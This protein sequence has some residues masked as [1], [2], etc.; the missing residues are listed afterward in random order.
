L[1]VPPQLWIE[2]LTWIFRFHHPPFVVESGALAGHNGP[3]CPYARDG[4]FKLLS[5]VIQQLFLWG[6][7]IALLTFFFI[8]NL[9]VRIVKVV[10]EKQGYQEVSDRSS[11]LQESLLAESVYYQIDNTGTTDAQSDVD[12][13]ITIKRVGVAKTV[14]IAIYNLFIDGN[15][16]LTSFIHVLIL[17]YQGI[18]EA[19][20]SF[21]SCGRY[22]SNYYAIT[23]TDI[24]CYSD[25]YKKWVP[26]YSLLMTYLL[27]LPIVFIVVIAILRRFRYHPRMVRALGVIYMTYQPLFYWFEGY[28]VFRRLLIIAIVFGSPAV[29][30]KAALFKVATPGVIVGIVLLAF[31]IIQRVSSPFITRTENLLEELSLATLT[32]IAWI[33]N[34]THLSA[35]QPYTR[36][37]FIVILIT[38]LPVGIILFLYYLLC[39]TLIRT[40]IARVHERMAKLYIVQQIGEYTSSYKVNLSLLGS[41]ITWFGSFFTTNSKDISLLSEKKVYSVAATQTS[42][43]SLRLNSSETLYNN[44]LGGYNEPAYDN[45]ADYPHETELID[46]EFIPIS[47]QERRSVNY[48]SPS[49]NRV[50]FDIGDVNRMTGYRL[51]QEEK[52]PELEEQYQGLPRSEINKELKRLWEQLSD[53]AK[54]EYER[55]A[56]NTHDNEDN[57]PFARSLP[58]IKRMTGYMLFAKQLRPEL[59]NSEDLT[60]SEISAE[61]RRLWDQLT[62]EAKEQFEKRALDR[63]ALVEAELGDNENT[64]NLLDT[65]ENAAPFDAVSSEYYATEPEY[66]EEISQEEEAEQSEDDSNNTLFG[67]PNVKRMTGYMIFS[68]I[69]RP[70]LENTE[71]P[72]RSQITRQLREMWDQLTDEEK[73]KYEQMARDRNAKAFGKVQLSDENI[74]APL[75]PVQLTSQ[76]TPSQ[77]KQI[78]VT[79]YKVFARETRKHV[80]RQKPNLDKSGVSDELRRL[81]EKLGIKEKNQYQTI[82][83]QMNAQ[84]ERSVAFEASS[85]SPKRLTGYIVFS[86]QLRRDIEQ[87][88]PELGKEEVK[89]EI[90]REWDALNEREKDQFEQEARV[91]NYQ[92]AQQ[93]LQKSPSIVRSHSLFSTQSPVHRSSRNIKRMTG[94]MM[95]ANQVRPD[96][97]NQYP[98]ARQMDISRKLASYWRALPE[99][100][101]D[102]FDTKL[103]DK[104]YKAAKARAAEIVTQTIESTPKL[105]IE[106]LEENVQKIE[107]SRRRSRTLPSSTSQQQ[108]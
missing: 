66:Q 90:R 54:E 58:N 80:M 100:I 23:N 68:K 15:A 44:E 104:N 34:L 108:S 65:E 52:R 40:V 13:N 95:F 56:R 94:Y 28:A 16:Y 17:T 27:L 73:H 10:R 9:V 49:E 4:Y 37:F 93:M 71:E 102:E 47:A 3:Y 57:L 43:D 86:K 62:D 25:R 70:E 84:A 1:L 72:E 96:L 32:L 14:S 101:Q 46:T 5:D 19:S 21:F 103:K 69:L 12:S 24:V 29:L 18:G 6:L 87:K 31:W 78:K 92:Q 105:S 39:N 81:W 79:A 97:E 45:A 38:A 88:Q 33:Y 22:G 55:R 107:E 50:R 2:W 64:S 20:F 76:S 99:D 91:H 74:S 30:A 53:E 7:P 60:D 51:F 11:M 36:L 41:L 75:S 89:H 59:A 35:F 82:A 83:D 8:I 98:N 42:I 106:E 77:A 85:K 48:T 63:N 26:F 61:I 67:L